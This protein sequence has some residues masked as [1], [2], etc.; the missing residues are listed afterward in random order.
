MVGQNPVGDS[1]LKDCVIEL[2]PVLKRDGLF[3]YPV[4]A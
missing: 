1:I 4:W 2:K 3:V